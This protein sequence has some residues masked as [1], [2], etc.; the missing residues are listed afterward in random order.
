MLDKLLDGVLWAVGVVR[1]R[2]KLAVEYASLDG[3]STAATA[4][5]LTVRW[6]Y[7]VRITNLSKEDAL[8][9]VVV[10]STISG[11]ETLGVHHIKGLE[12]L[13]L[14]RRL[15]KELDREVVVAAHHDFHGALE[16][17][18]LKDF[19]L[20]LRYKSSNGVTCYTDYSRTRRGELNIWTIREPRGK[21]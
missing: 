18:E 17:Q 15:E 9:L 6:G 19:A 1:N 13:E 7:R 8:E 2:P 4:G 10:R 14:V 20:V 3:M 11:M 5:R 21:G 16:P 12:H